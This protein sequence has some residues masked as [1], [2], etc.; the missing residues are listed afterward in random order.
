[1]KNIFNSYPAAYKFQKGSVYYDVKANPDNHFK[2]MYLLSLEVE[3]LKKKSFSPFPI[4]NTWIP[5]YMTIDTEIAKHHL[6]EKNDYNKDSTKEDIWSNIVNF[7]RKPVKEQNDGLKF[8]GTVFTDSVRLSI[9]K[10][11]YDTS[12]RGNARRQ[13]ENSANN[14]EEFRYIDDLSREEQNECVGKCVLIDLGR[15]NL[16]YCMHED[17]DKVNK[18]TY[19][20]TRNQRNVERRIRKF[21]KFREDL[22]PY[23]VKKAEVQLTKVNSSTVSVDQYI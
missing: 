16:L 22:K 2:A 4:R 5:S 7:K 3:K 9:V 18:K 20:Y 8:Q 23:K 13:K 1:V 11:N 12:R 21:K 17:D 19:R 6:L 10:Q 14:K 15:L